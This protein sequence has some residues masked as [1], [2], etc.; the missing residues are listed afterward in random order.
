MDTEFDLA[1]ISQQ[2]AAHTR[3]PE[4]SA[5]IRKILEIVKMDKS[6]TA[7]SFKAEK[8]GRDEKI[9]NFRSRNYNKRYSLI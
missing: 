8:Y 5:M 4:Y 9:Q 1:E 3:S 6:V 7:S 2:E